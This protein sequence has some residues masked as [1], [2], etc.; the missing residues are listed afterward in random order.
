MGKQLTVKAIQQFHQRGYYL[1]LDVASVEE[2][3]GMRRQLEAFEAESGGALRG[4]NPVSYTHLTL[5]TIYSV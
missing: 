5:P 2:I 1:P 3:Q 4:T